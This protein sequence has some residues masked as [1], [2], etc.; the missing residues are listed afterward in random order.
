VI[1]AAISDGTWAF[2]GVLVANG[3]MLAAL[4]IR[5]GRARTSI[6][7]INTAVNHQLAGTPTL[8]ERVSDIEKAVAT[9][10]LHRGWERH[11]FTTL[12]HH[13]GCILP[14]YPP[15]PHDIEGDELS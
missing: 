8:V 7:Q 3:A 10:Q 6:E 15:T 13:V 11:A 2:L 12:A 1:V 9:A 5:Q 4:F 14:P